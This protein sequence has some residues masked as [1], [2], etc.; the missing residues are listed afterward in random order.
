M[1]KPDDGRRSMP[2]LNC[3]YCG[4]RCADVP[5]AMFKNKS[6]LVKLDCVSENDYILECPHCHK[7][8]GLHIDNIDFINTVKLIPI[9]GTVNC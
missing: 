2:K 5:N 7:K 9:Y 3:P 6:R 4:K 1:N 8:V